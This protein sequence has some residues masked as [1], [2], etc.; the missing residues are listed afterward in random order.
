MISV[1]NRQR[2]IVSP[3]DALSGQLYGPPLQMLQCDHSRQ[4]S[5]TRS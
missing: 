1:R 5:K 2:G 3:T 4:G